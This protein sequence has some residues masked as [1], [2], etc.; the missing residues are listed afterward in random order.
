MLSQH[1]S[2]AILGMRL[3]WLTMSSHVSPVQLLWREKWKRQCLSRVIQT[4]KHPGILAVQ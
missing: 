4:T 2:N 1:Y 3:L